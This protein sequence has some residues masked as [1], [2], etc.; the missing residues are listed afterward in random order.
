MRFFP[1]DG[2]AAR[3]APYGLADYLDDL[4]FGMLDAGMCSDGEEPDAAAAEALRVAAWQG[5]IER[6]GLALLH[7]SWADRSV[8]GMWPAAA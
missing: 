3:R 2:G 8:S 5:V 7:A 4:G 6:G 1:L